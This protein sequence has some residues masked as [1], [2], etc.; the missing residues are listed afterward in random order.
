MNTGEG[1]DL[2]GGSDL[3]VQTVT[4]VT[5]GQTRNQSLY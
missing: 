5:A 2:T 1:E 3:L 4:F